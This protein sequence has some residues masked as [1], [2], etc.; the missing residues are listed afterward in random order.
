M[1]KYQSQII[2]NWPQ[3]S[4]VCEQRN[5]LKMIATPRKIF[6]FPKRKRQKASNDHWN[7]IAFV[8]NTDA[9]QLGVD[10]QR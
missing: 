9:A 7:G 3:S 10:N 4:Y 2:I 6:C 5:M 1:L 8:T